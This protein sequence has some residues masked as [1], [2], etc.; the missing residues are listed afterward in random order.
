MLFCRRSQGRTTSTSFPTTKR[1]KPIPL[2]VTTHALER[3][4]HIAAPGMPC[5]ETG[6]DAAES[7]GP[8]PHANMGGPPP[9]H[10]PSASL[11]CPS[12]TR[13]LSPCHARLREPCPSLRRGSRRACRRR[14]ACSCASSAHR[15]APC[16]G[17]P[18]VVACRYGQERNEK[19]E[20]GG[21]H[22]ADWFGNDMWDSPE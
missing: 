15:R 10:G 1:L 8:Q 5:A 7:G 16:L 22:I 13:W 4:R 21:R 9:R 12:E 2:P 3:H 11:L 18:V 19:G 6:G 14:T 20:E 17:Q